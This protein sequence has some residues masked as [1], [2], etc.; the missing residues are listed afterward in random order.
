M[1]TSEAMY[2]KVVST[3]ELQPTD[4]ILKPFT[5]QML[6]G[7]IARA[8]ERRGIFLPTW[9]LIG[10]GNLREAVNSCASGEAAHPRFATEF[11]RLRAELYLELK[12]FGEAEALYRAVLAQRPL[13]WASLGLARAMHAQGRTD[14]AREVLEKLVAANPRLMAAYDL[15]ARCHEAAGNPAQ[16]QKVLEEAVGISPH[17]VRRLRTLGDVALEAGDVA[18]AEKSFKQVVAKA[19]YSEF[20]DPE[21][22]VNLVKALVRRGDPAQA[23]SVIRD[24]ERSLRGNPKLDACKAISSALVHQATGNTTAAISDLNAAVRTAGVLSASLRVDLA[25][26]CLDNQM[27]QQAGEVMLSVMNDP[28]SGVT[29]QDAIGVFEKAGRPDLADGMGQQL[30]AQAQILLGVADEKRNM[31]DVR[32]AVQTLLEALHIAPANLQVMIAVVGGIIRQINEMGW[33]H[34]LGELCDA[35][36]EK[37]RTLD[38]SHPRLLALADEFS[39]A[40]RRYGIST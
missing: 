6:S 38:A 7:R 32:G 8:V 22:H 16:S 36:L 1:L 3:A 18:A 23:G 31:G 37:I 33:D 24:L 12:E 10:K 35:Q 14:E 40:K 26:Q 30:K 39:G 2:G 17:V 34:P 19:R 11:A 9:Q 4:Y 5:V 27:D 20:R 13:G 29:P 25:R 15:L 21:D 28:A